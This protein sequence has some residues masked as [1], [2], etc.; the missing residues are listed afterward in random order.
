M[1]K[2]L[3]AAS[4]KGDEEMSNENDGEYEEQRQKLR[5]LFFNKPYTSGY[6]AFDSDDDE[7]DSETSDDDD[8]IDSGRQMEQLVFSSQNYYSTAQK[9]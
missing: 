7:Y 2:D 5:N 9:Q 6:A 1:W 3:E 4:E 8:D